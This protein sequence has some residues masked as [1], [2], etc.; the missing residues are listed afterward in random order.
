VSARVLWFVIV[1]GGCLP[2]PLRV[3]AAGDLQPGGPIADPLGALVLDGDLRFVNLE[4]PLTARGVESGLD[5][6]GRPIAGEPVHFAAPPERAAWLGGRFDVV[7]LANNHALDQGEAGRDDTAR[8]LATHAVAAAWPGHDARVSRKGRALRVIARD[9][10]PED[11]LDLE[12][13]AAAELIEAVRHASIPGDAVLVSLHWGHT[14]SLLPTAE[15]RQ[16]AARLAEAGASAILGHGPH[17]LQ[18]VALLPRGRAGAGGSTVVA[19]SLGNLAFGCRCTEVGDAYLL[20]FTLDA[21]GGAT[22]VMAHPLRAGLRVPAERSNDPDLHALIA[23]LSRDLGATAR[24]TPAGVA[25]GQG[26]WVPARP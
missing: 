17:T 13:G 21:R 25:I 7:S 24:V 16:L 22:Q 10:A 4:S 23:D 2:P 12:R 15:Q 1:L 8:A 6:E 11:P 9:F 19:Y 20:A 14:G 18:G 5:A 26:S 3:L